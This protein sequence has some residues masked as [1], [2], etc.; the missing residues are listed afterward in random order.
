MLEYI[1]V[2]CVNAQDGMDAI[3]VAVDAQCDVEDYHSQS[4]EDDPDCFSALI[5]VSP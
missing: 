4:D 5:E 3:P 1:P 2:C